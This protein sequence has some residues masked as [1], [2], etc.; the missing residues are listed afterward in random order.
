MQ[1]AEPGPWRK[2]FD[3]FIRALSGGFLFGVPLLYTM[4][5]GWIGSYSALCRLGV[6]LVLHDPAQGE[7]RVKETLLYHTLIGSPPIR[8]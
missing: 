8:T 7:L 5:M 4:E 2:E 3:D 6:F 1:R